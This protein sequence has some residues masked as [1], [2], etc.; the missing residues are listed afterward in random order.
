MRASIRSSLGLLDQHDRRLLGLA[1]L[2]QMTTSLLDLAGVALI[3]IVGALSMTSVGGQQPPVRLASIVSA[4]GLGGVANAVLIAVFGGAAALLLLTKS[5]ISPLLLARVFKFLARRQVLVAGRL[6]GELLS[7]P[8]TFVQS[9]S[10]QATAGALVQGIGYAVVMVLGQT[11][12]AA[13][14]ASL[15]AILSLVLLIVNPPVAICAIA[16]FA[17]VGVGLQ[18]LLGNRAARFG[19]M[20][21]DSEIH[22]IRAVQEALGTYRELTVSDRRAFYVARIQDLRSQDADAAAG[23]QLINILPKYA[24]EAALVFGGFALAAVLFSTQSVAVAAGTF[25]LFLAAATR[26]MPS[27]LRLQTAALVVRSSAGSASMTFALAED[28]GRPVDAPQADAVRENI[29]QA[30]RHGYPD[31]VPVIDLKRVSFTYPGAHA[32]AVRQICMQAGRGQS[33]ALIGSSG[34]GKSTLADV[35]LGVLEPGEG[36]VTVGGLPP[37]QATVRWPGGIAYVPQEVVLSD[38]SVRANVAL[39]LPRELI[40]DD[41]VWDALRRAQLDDYLRVQPEGLDTQVGEHGLRISGGQRQRLG[42][43]RALFTRPRL[44]VLDEA[45]SALDAETEQAITRMLEDLE[46]DVTT[47]IIAHR[48]STVRHVDVVMYLDEGSIIAQGTFDQVLAQVPALRRQAAL[49]G[50]KPA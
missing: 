46:E 13:S 16:F 49:M 18:R 31:F 36:E 2:A 15:L 32:P 21:L 43:A 6:T 5:L 3:G 38:D 48:L 34:A 28:L 9:R 26:V 25:A 35:I 33:V 27:L 39:G 19:R 23:L 45:T 42:I 14:E 47:V 37:S 24:Y 12:V 41:M 20:H 1:I 11:V 8:L 30:L 22:S 29:R 40:D 44:L 10:S 7:R 50:L 17:L 4:V